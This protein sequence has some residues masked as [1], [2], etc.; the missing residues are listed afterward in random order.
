[1]TCRRCGATLLYDEI[2]NGFCDRCADIMF[3]QY[4]ARRDWSYWHDDEKSTQEAAGRAEASG[5]IIDTK[6]D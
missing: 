5:A 6:S 4:D 2:E 3:E 1:M